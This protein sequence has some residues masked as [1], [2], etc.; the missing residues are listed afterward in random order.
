MNGG[1]ISGNVAT[2]AGEDYAEEALCPGGGGVWAGFIN[3]ITKIIIN[4]GVISFNKAIGSDSKGGGI[5][6]SNNTQIWLSG[7]TVSN[8]TANAGGGVYND[9]GTV[10]E[11]GTVFSGNSSPNFGL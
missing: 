11:M 8:N 5:Y 10:M 3:G 9:G 6:M 1:I 4:N 2:P 7:G